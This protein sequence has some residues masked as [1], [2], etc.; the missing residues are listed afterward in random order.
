MY[1]FCRFKVCQSRSGAGL[2]RVRKFTSR[3]REPVRTCATKRDAQAH[4]LHPRRSAVKSSKKIF[5]RHFRLSALSPPASP[6]RPAYH[7]RAPHRVPLGGRQAVRL[8]GN[9]QSPASPPRPANHP[10]APHRVP[11]GGRQAVRLAGN[12]Q[13]PASPPL[14]ANHQRPPHRVPLGGRQA[15][16][17]APMS[18]PPTRPSCA[19]PQ[20]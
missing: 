16:R 5:A 6:P 17:L 14:P 11:L 2:A 9:P 20:R 4:W 7:P 8:A 15:V 10:R 1:P 12:P 19:S 3:L 18:P 13:S